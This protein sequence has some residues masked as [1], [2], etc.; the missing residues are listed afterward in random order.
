MCLHVIAQPM[1]CQKAVSFDT[2]MN[3]DIKLQVRPAL[4]FGG[5]T[6]L[7]RRSM[8]SLVSN[9]WEVERVRVKDTILCV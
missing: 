9:A 4:K 2:S 7:L 3:A 1:A 5:D 6:T 8:P